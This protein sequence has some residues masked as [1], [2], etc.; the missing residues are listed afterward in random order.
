[1]R[2]E[3][4][5]A[6]ERKATGAW[7]LT[8]IL[9]SLL[10]VVT[11]AKQR[12]ATPTLRRRECSQASASVLNKSGQ[13]RTVRVEVC[14]W[15]IFGNQHIAE[16]PEHGF[17]LVQLTGGKLTTTID[18]KPA[19]QHQGEFWVVPASAKMTMDASG[20]TTS[21]EVTKFSIH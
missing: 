1:M 15:N 11:V 19:R 16:F 21:I 20:E 14:E 7:L 17:L 10:P 12:G 13:S 4:H 18:G 3:A 8:T 9:L 2:D 5:I 6:M